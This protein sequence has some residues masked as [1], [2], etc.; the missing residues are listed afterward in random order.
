MDWQLIVTIAS[1]LTA[2]GVIYG[3]ARKWG[4]AISKLIA[5]TGWKKLNAKEL[6][7]NAV[8]KT[9]ED[10]S[11]QLMSS[12]AALGDKLD[13]IHNDLSTGL[14]ENTKLTLKLELTELFRDHPERID[15]IETAFKQY[16]DLG[17]NSYVKELY[18]EWEGNYLSKI[19]KQEVNKGGK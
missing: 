16:T 14:N 13:S 15:A 11:E 1:I 10:Y 9:H 12:L 6:E 18:E 2:I 7:E 5:K 3:S 17:G 19:A 8:W 4:G